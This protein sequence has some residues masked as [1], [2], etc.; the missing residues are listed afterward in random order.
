VLFR[1]LGLVVAVGWFAF[2]GWLSGVK[3]VP[4]VPVSTLS[5][6]PPLP[7]AQA[8]QP[9]APVPVVVPSAVRPVRIQGGMTTIRGGTVEWLWVS[10]DGHLMTEDEI[11]GESG[12]TVSS[13]LVRGVRVLSGTGVRYGGTRSEPAWASGLAPTSL[14]ESPN[15]ESPMSRTR[16]EEPPA[17]APRGTE[18]LASPPG[19]LASP[20]GVLAT[21]PGL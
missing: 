5:P 14:V 7:A 17:A 1:S 4:A 11:A 2:G 16:A 10:E 21:P 6:P 19:I 13:R 20:P 8:S 15:N 12:G 18:I 3:P 9:L